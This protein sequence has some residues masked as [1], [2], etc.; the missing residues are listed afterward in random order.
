MS[1]KNLYHKA[2]KNI[3]AQNVWVAKPTTTMIDFSLKQAAE[4]HVL[5]VVNFINLQAEFS[6]ETLKI[7]LY[8]WG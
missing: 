5:C 1:K 8:E 7:S 6:C 3:I 2:H 4:N